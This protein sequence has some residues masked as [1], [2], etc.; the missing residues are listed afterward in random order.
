[1]DQPGQMTKFPKNLENT[2]ENDRERV[3]ISFDWKFC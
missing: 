1:M 3:P 2:R